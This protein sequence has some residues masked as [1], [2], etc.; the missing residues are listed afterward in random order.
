MTM[1]KQDYE[2]ISSGIRGVHDDLLAQHEEF[3]RDLRGVIQN[4]MLELAVRLAVDFVT[5]NPRFKGDQFLIDALGETAGDL[6]ISQYKEA[7]NSA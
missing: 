5:V 4:A 2:R 1:Q 6:A 3:D 7:I